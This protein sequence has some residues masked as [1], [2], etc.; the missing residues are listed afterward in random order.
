MREAVR[1]QLS[2]LYFCCLESHFDTNQ[3]YLIELHFW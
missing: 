3:F 2:E 1:L